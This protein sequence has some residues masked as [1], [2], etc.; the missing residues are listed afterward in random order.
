MLT[1][2]LALVISARG[3]PEIPNYDYRVHRAG[4]INLAVSNNSRTGRVIGLN[5]SEQSKLNHYPKGT[6]RRYSW[7]QLVIG[8]IRNGDTLV[9]H[10]F[11]FWPASLSQQIASGDTTVAIV[12][13]PW[14]SGNASNVSLPDEEYTFVYYDTLTDPDY[15]FVDRYSGL[16]GGYIHK[17]LGL[18]ITQTSRVWSFAHVT[19]VILFEYRIANIG[20][21]LISE[22]FFGVWSPGGAQGLQIGRG[23]HGRDDVCG[24]VEKYVPALPLFE[25]C[26]IELHYDLAWA[27]DNDGDPIGDSLGFDQHSPTEVTGV[28]ILEPSSP[29][30]KRG[31]NWW[32]GS[33]HPEND[34]GPRNRFN[35]GRAFREFPFGTGSPVYDMGWYDVM[36]SSE[37]D[38]QQLFAAFDHSYDGWL[39][40]PVYPESLAVEG[41]RDGTGSL[42]SVGP[43]DLAPG[44]STTF[45]FAFVGGLGF[46]TDPYNRINNW[47]PYNPQKYINNLDFRDLMLNA[48]NARWTYDNP[49]FDTDGDGYKGVFQVCDRDSVVTKLTRHVDSSGIYPVVFV[50]LDT[51]LQFTYEDTVWIEGDGV[52]DY[53]AAVPPIQPLVKFT[54]LSGKI[55]LDWNGLKSETTADL[56]THDL[57]FEGYHVYFGV[58]AREKDLTL[59]SSYDREDFA[60]WY[61]DEDIR[62]GEDHSSWVVLRKPFTADEARVLYAGGSLDWHPLDNDVDNLL[63]VGDSLFYFT[64]QDWNQS[65]LRDTTTIHK[66]YPDEPRPHTL[67]LDS[68]FTQDTYFTDPLTGEE[69]YFEGGEL[70]PDGERFKF[71]EYRFVLDNLLASQQYYIAVT[72]FDFGSPESGIP[73]LETDPSAT[74]VEALAQDRVV[75]DE[76][77]AVNVYPNPYR[78]DANYREDGFEGRGRERFIA[79]RVRA[80]HF[81]NLP[82]VCEIRI[83]SLD[84][85]LIRQIPHNKFADDPSAMHAVWDVITRNLQVPV[86]G[87]YYWIVQTPDGKQQI[88]KLVL[89]M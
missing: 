88:G 6:P 62:G 70:T 45:A 40:P 11:E 53:R 7:P 23:E 47:D 43:I 24:F 83:Y 21:T 8:G 26:A 81:S 56:F 4:N 36:S 61:F 39:P 20:H 48:T 31:Y 10:F 15:V 18:R 64:K 58:T 84:G 72:A 57:D 33:H 73:F 29:F 34:F 44:Q 49:G 59:V 74:A 35:D 50:T 51:L 55:T 27:A 86:S 67:I 38:Y 12:R 75:Q 82:P 41:T 17:P 66:V 14:A 3:E 80:V 28:M 85:D 2:L 19:D 77:L 16:L 25:Q 32:N 37:R 89:I 65:E 30:L 76:E 87:I 13:A 5:L 46:V 71:Y 79:D 42:L 54:T 22:C 52:P 69:F 9:S 1:V 63:R 68:A 78:A 60:Q